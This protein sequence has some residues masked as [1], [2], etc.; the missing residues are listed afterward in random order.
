VVTALANQAIKDQALQ[1]SAAH[2]GQ[3]PNRRPGG[4]AQITPF[5]AAQLAS[6][7]VWDQRHIGG[8]LRG[9]ASYRM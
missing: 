2:A 8:Y 9:D 5:G 3:A 4:R 6:P 7:A 1:I